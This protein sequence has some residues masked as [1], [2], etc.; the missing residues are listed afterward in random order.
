MAVSGLPGVIGEDVPN[1]AR[2]IPNGIPWLGIGGMAVRVIGGLSVRA[3][4]GLTFRVI[5][6]LAPRISEGLP[7]RVIGKPGEEALS[8]RPFPWLFTGETLT[9]PGLPEGASRLC[10]GEK[11]LTLPGIPEGASRLFE[12]ETTLTLLATADPGS[13]VTLLDETRGALLCL[14]G[15]V[16]AC[17]KNG[18]GEIWTAPVVLGAANAMVAC[19]RTLKP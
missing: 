10:E 18:D 17:V 15:D 11:T 16:P 19:K 2:G 5:G 7:T 1:V 14:I 12:G 13:V 9:L 6:G 8:M 4:G 3:I